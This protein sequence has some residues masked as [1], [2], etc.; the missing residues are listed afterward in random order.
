MNDALID[1][2]LVIKDIDKRPII[3]RIKELNI[4]INKDIKLKQLSN[5]FNEAK[6]KYDAKEISS[7]A[8]I[9]IKTLFYKHPVILEYRQLFSELNLSVMRF[10]KE[11][12]TLLKMHNTCNHS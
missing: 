3:K 7:D 6:E 4:L 11:L 5:D 8:F 9:K 10:N 1:I 12:N 2:D